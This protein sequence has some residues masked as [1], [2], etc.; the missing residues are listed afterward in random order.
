MQGIDIFQDHEFLN[1]VSL[2]E[3]FDNNDYRTIY[4]MDCNN[5]LG[6][7][8][9]YKV[10]TG[11][12]LIYYEFEV[13]SC[14]CDLPTYDNIIE[15]NHCK[16]GREECKLLDG[17]FLY[18]G[19][20][21]LSINMMSNHADTIGFPLKHYKGISVVIYMDEI[22][23]EVPKILKDINIDIYNLKEKF[24]T[25]DKCFVMRAK[26]KIEHIFSELYSVPESVQ[27]AYFKLKVLELLVFLSITDESQEEEKEYYSKEQVERIKEIKK[28]ITKNSQHRY[29]I[30]E[31][32][33]MYCISPTGLKTYFKGI[34]GTSIATYVKEYRIKNAAISLRQTKNSIADVA[35]S[36]GYESQSKFAAAFK[37]IIGISPLEYRKKCLEDILL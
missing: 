33:K 30:E 8:T 2:V 22:V 26:D 10:F 16:E 1:R 20:G 6:I 4:K 13:A 12:E 21:D 32:A 19:E 27:K 28:F 9:V 23:N 17:S 7:M 14:L 34:Y 29:T 35:L 18:M 11:I 5:G 24:C 37:K 36:V 25:H 3:K 31:L 15:I